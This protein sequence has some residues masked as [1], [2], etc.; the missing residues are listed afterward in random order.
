MTTRMI[1][2][3]GH[4][5]GEA[6]DVAPPRARRRLPRPHRPSMPTE[7]ARETRLPPFGAARRNSQ[8]RGCNEVATCRRPHRCCRLLPS[9]CPF[10]CH[11]P[12]SRCRSRRSHQPVVLRAP[13]LMARIVITVGFLVLGLP[14]C[15]VP[16]RRHSRSGSL[17][18]EENGPVARYGSGRAC[19]LDSSAGRRRDRAARAIFA[20]V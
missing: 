12:P 1:A 10:R 9:R 5:V 6:G 11:M 18:A 13:R 17:D 16:F 8:V 14:E 19:S 3:T 20:R 7:V 4:G 15:C 2:D